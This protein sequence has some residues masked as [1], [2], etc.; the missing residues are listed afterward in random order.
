MMSVQRFFRG[1]ALSARFTTVR[2]VVF[3]QH[4]RDGVKP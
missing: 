2:R 4:V 3:D 1:R